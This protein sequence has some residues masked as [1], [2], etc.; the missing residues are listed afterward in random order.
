MMYAPLGKLFPIQQGMPIH[1]EGGNSGEIDL[2]ITPVFLGC[3][4]RVKRGCHGMPVAPVNVT[5]TDGRT[6]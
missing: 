2:S 4:A 1:E 3:C 6:G 5:M